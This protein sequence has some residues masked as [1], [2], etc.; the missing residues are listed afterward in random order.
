M[1]ALISIVFTSYNHRKYLKQ[2]L[3]SIINQSLADFELIIVDDCSTDGSQEILREYAN[4]DDRIR[5]FLLKKN[6]GSYVL[7]SNLGASKATAPYII[8]AQCDDYAERR[9]LEILY[10]LACEHPY[11]GVI[12]SSSIL[13][14]ADN[15]ILGNDYDYRS[16]AF[17]RH[18]SKN[19]VI[20]R[21]QMQSFLLESCVIPNLSAALI[22][23][24]LFEKS[25]RLSSD[26]LVIADWDLWL[27]MTLLCDFYYVRKPLNNF[28]QHGA[29]IRSSIK[30]ETQIKE[31]FAMYYKYFKLMQ[32]KK[33]KKIRWELQ[34]VFIWI[35]YIKG[36][37][38]FRTRCFFP[39]QIKDLKYSFYFPVIFLFGSIVVGLRWCFRKLVK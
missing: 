30:L 33:I 18:C 38:F 26:Y 21:R 10:N 3:D 39:L 17:R 6:T 34:I 29:T 19:T 23:R 35:S 9:Q 2:A 1:E 32:F 7:S 31:I 4:T 27:Q 15:N 8:F 36:N 25:C 11:I 13:I 20:D 5:L 28:R 37:I 16:K 22:R 14:D 12:Y 24:D